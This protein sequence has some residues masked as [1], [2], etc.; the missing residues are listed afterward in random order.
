MLVDYLEECCE[1]LR[2]KKERYH[3]LNLQYKKL[4]SRD[5][6]DEMNILKKEFTKK[7]QEANEH[8]YDELLELS[9]IKTYFPQLY[10]LFLEDPSIGKLIKRK[11]WLLMRKE[12]NEQKAK[13]ELKNI[14]L[15]REE[16][17]DA[18][19]FV[20]KWPRERI[21]AKSLVATW[22]ALKNQIKGTLDKEEVIDKIQDIDSQLKREG[23]IILINE[24]MIEMPLNRFARKLMDLISSEEM[25]KEHAE[26]SKGK[27]SVKEYEALKEYHKVRKKRKKYERLIKHL[28]IAS[29]GYLSKLKKKTKKSKNENLLTKIAQSIKIRKINEKKW[30]A[31]MRKRLET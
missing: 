24:S 11:D 10:G 21:D 7:E 3:K 6:R 4:Y 18:K 5:I 25:K 26:K 1:I 19:A 30:L 31:E 9:L 27:G 28:L 15:K 17:I 8:L 20:H 13:K 16:L 14:E 2:E 29:S 23:W 22:P 12:M